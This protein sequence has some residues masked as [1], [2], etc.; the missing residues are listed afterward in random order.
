[1]AP[2]HLTQFRIFQVA[3]EL[4]EAVPAFLEAYGKENCVGI[5]ELIDTDYVDSEH[6]DV[7][8]AT[9][10][11]W[12]RCRKAM[13]GQ[14]EVRQRVWVSEKVRKFLVIVKSRSTKLSH[15][16]FVASTNASE[17][18]SVMGIIKSVVSGCLVFVALLSTSTME[19]LRQRFRTG[20][21]HRPASVDRGLRKILIGIST[22][23]KLMQR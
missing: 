18:S 13:G 14:L 2:P 11:E 17:N 9:K 1:M 21:R 6:S 15:D 22:R 23:Q 12:E 20:S 16:S 5:E 4:R 8:E 3:E 10:E 19:A 7:G